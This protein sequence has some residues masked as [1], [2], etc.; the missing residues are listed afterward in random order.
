MTPSAIGPIE[1]VDDGKGSADF[2]PMLGVRTFAI[3]TGPTTAASVA[4]VP[5]DALGMFAL[6][7]HSVRD[8][9]GAELA[10]DA[11][12]RTFVDGP[13]IAA[14]TV[15]VADN[16]GS[17][18]AR[19]GLDI[20]RRDQGVLPLTGSPIG[21]ARSQLITGVLSQVAE[22]FAIEVQ[23]D[24]KAPVAV[25]DVGTVFDAAASQGVLPSRPPRLGPGHAPY[26]PVASSLIKDAVAS[27]DVV[28]VPAQPVMVGDRERV[29]WWKV[30]PLTGV[31]TDVMDD[32]IRSVGG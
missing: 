22:R 30:D 24:P 21:A 11:G 32:G 29:G 10:I 26:G 27:G 5:K 25:T 9:L 18:V 4:V 1:L 19:L 31:T 14:L 8:A 13:N 15:D 7:Y 12:S 16:G 3:A 28:V 17:R 20:L 2:L 23:A 6:A